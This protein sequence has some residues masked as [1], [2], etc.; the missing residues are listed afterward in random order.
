MQFRIVLDKPPAGIDFGLQVGKGPGYKTIQVQ[1]SQGKDLE[2]TFELEALRGPMVQGSGTE[3]FVYIDIGTCA[4]QRDTTC[5]RRLK[6]QL[7]AGLFDG[8]TKAWKVRMPGTARDG[9]PMC[10]SVKPFPGWIAE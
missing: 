9:G 1:R 3:R 2:F 5:A 8:K 10:A 4:G 6:V 7:D